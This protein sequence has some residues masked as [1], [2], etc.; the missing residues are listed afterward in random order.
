MTTSI[1]K[2]VRRVTKGTHR[3]RRVVVT[4]DAPDMIGFRFAKTRTTYWTTIAACMDMAIRQEVAAAQ[5][6]RKKAKKR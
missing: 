2:A 3:G 4:I 5:L 1:D 6:A